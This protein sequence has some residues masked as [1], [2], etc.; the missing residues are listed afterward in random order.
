[1]HRVL[2]VAFALL[3]LCV[4]PVSAQSTPDRQWVVFRQSDGL[5][6]NDVYAV[7]AQNDVIWVGTANGVSRFDGHWQSFVA[8]MSDTGPHTEVDLN[9]VTALAAANLEGVVWAGTE[10]GLLV[11]GEKDRGWRI[12]KEF[13]VP[14]HALAVSDDI[15]WIGTK[16]GLFSL[17]DN[18]LTHVTEVGAIPVLALL[19][20]NDGTTFVGS[21]QALWRISI[22]LTEIESLQLLD[23]NHVPIA[24][25][26]T[27]IWDDTTSHIW[28]STATSVFQYST[29]TG[30][31]AKY[32]QPFGIETAE[33]TD[34]KGVARE[35]VW[36]ASKDSGAAQ[37][38]L[39]G[40]EVVSMQSWGSHVQGGLSANDIRS[41][42]TDR[43][44]SVW[45]ATSTGLFRYQPWAFQPIDDRIYS[46]PV[47]D[48]L[49]DRKGQLWIATA[50]EGVQLRAERYQ[51]ATIFTSDNSELP[52][53]LVFNLE[54][55]AAGRVWAI[56]SDGAAYFDAQR[57]QRPLAL[58]QLNWTSSGVL[59]ADKL[60]IWLGTAKG[61]A[62]FQLDDESVTIMPPLAGRPISAIE[63]D[64]LGRLWVADI[65]GA[66]WRREIDGA[67]SNAAGLDI[68]DT[69]TLFRSGAR[70]HLR[71]N[72]ASLDIDDASDVPVTAFYPETEPPGSMI[73][74]FKGYGI[75]R[76]RDTG[77]E[78]ID[79]NRRGSSDQVSAMLADSN[80]T[81][82][83]VGSETG[84]TRFDQYGGAFFDAQDGLQP[85]AIH[86]IAQDTTGAYWFGG[87]RGLSHYVPEQ[88][89]PWIQLSGI[90]GNDLRASDE[91]WQVLSS[92]PIEVNFNYGDLQTP[93]EKLRVYVR[94]IDGEHTGTW[95]PLVSGAF[96]TSLPATGHYHLEY[97]VRD[98]SFNYSP[99]SSVALVAT[100]APKFTNIPLLGKME[101]RIFQL[102][103][104]FAFLTVFG[105]GYVSL[106]IVQHRRRVSDVVAR[107]Y[108][109]YISGEPVRRE[110]MFFGRHELLQRI[111]STLHNNSIMIHGER[112]IGK[113]TLLYQLA[114]T[115]RQIDDPEYWFVALYVDLEGT[116]EEAF[117]HLL[118][119]ETTQHVR[120]LEK[121]DE[122]QHRVLDELYFHA[123]LATDYNDRTFSRDLRQV[124]RMLE[125]YSVRHCNGRQVRL[126]LLMD[127]MDTLSRYHHLIQQQLR[128]IFMREFAASVGAVV[129][130]IE[131]NKDWE[132]VESPWFNLFNEIAMQPF[133][134]EEAIQLLVEP[135]RG[136]YIFEPEVI[137]FILEQSDGRPY[138][139][140]QYAMEAV[141]EMLCYKRR[142]I[143]MHD[144]LIAHAIIQW[145]SQANKMQTGDLVLE[146]LPVAASAPETT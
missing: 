128:R 46:L 134:R 101:N 80:T 74:A 71:S 86:A 48:L 99:I 49:F 23:A 5:A 47:N 41:I 36:V 100:T 138:R 146:V 84:L 68:D 64:S 106:E 79:K 126:I 57:W 133:G 33:I 122:T 15:V 4:S 9:K 20:W 144:V 98:Q 51:K 114:N 59:K 61:L 50:G 90:D 108:N 77:W 112:R 76:T 123:T 11:V 94:L 19:Q 44:G 115:L 3:F 125:E 10:A 140:Q 55:D 26:F 143:K 14:I 75:Y 97:M 45:F 62:Y 145:D 27:G 119:E 70:L 111:V 65:K 127:E 130:G 17:R 2:P 120:S 142:R 56:T 34:I 132:R 105:F 6:S 110:D 60:G 95:Q 104:I 16:Q 139:I 7:L 58:R 37:F 82:I 117:F 136:Y 113:T 107:G 35:S 92:E 81:T 22:D 8:A 141:N 85:G 31:I 93:P 54:E 39:T 83:W 29:L 103:V 30:E 124:I 28:I 69:S 121:V 89:R 1:L 109:P 73:A 12:V 135:V 63:I 21:A 129:A 102:L 13:G 18:I 87:D 40:N 66:L 96:H 67:W 24:G 116:A 78:A 43:D 88:G 42:A 118:M 38:H 72:V 137:E 131:I 53:D 91:P 52:S 32:A 25:P